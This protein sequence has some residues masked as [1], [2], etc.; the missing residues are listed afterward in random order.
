MSTSFHHAFPSPSPVL[1]NNPPAS[2]HPFDP[3]GIE[4]NLTNLGLL[5]GGKHRKKSDRPRQRTHETASLTAHDRM[6]ISSFYLSKS[7][8]AAQRDPQPIID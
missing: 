2:S 4:A 6:H 8:S 3:L 5:G 7:F 1:R